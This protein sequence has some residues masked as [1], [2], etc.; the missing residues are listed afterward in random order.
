MKNMTYLAVAAAAV[1]A[2]IPASAQC[3]ASGAATGDNA[4]PIQL[5]LKY[6]WKNA[7]TKPTALR[8]AIEKLHTVVRTAFDENARNQLLVKFNGKCDQVSQLESA[9]SAAGV[10]AYVIN[11]AHVSIAFKTQPGANLRAAIDA[12]GKVTGALYVKASGSGVEVHADLNLLSMYDLTAA[13]APFKC[14]PVVE[15]TFEYLRF[16]VVEGSR[17]KFETVAQDVKGVMVVRLEK[18]DVVGMWVNKAA[19]KAEQIEKLEGFKLK[20]L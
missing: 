1:L 5:V 3:P 18:D 11:H 15:K 16:Q 10:P 4:E 8:T 6:T 2:A 7:E 9:A 19:V 17:P 12:V 20:R 14:E 13:V